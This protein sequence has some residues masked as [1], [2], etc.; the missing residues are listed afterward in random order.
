MPTPRS[1][2]SQTYKSGKFS[3]IGRA[4]TR[5]SALPLFFAIDAGIAQSPVLLLDVGTENAISM[6]D[7]D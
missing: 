1:S 6:C 4:D 3:L 7:G 5:V 2:S